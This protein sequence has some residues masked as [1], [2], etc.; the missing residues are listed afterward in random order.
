MKQVKNHKK[1][2][3]RC[4]QEQ[5]EY[6][7][8]FAEE[9]P[10]LLQKKICSSNPRQMKKLWEELAR[11]LNGMTGPTRNTQK[12]KETLNHW[13]IQVRCRARKSKTSLTS[14]GGGLL[15]KFSEITRLEERALATFGAIDGHS[16]LPS[17]RMEASSD[18]V[19]DNGDIKDMANTTQ[20]T[21][22]IEPESNEIKEE[23]YN[24][25]QETLDFAPEIHNIKQEI[26][27]EANSYR[28]CT[29]EQL[30]YYLAFV[31]KHPE[32]LQN[33]I[34]SANPRKTKT[35]W[36]ELAGNLNDMAGPTRNT[37]KWKETLNH[38]KYQLRGRARKGKISL[39][40]TLRNYNKM[41]KFEERA[42]A[43]FRA[44]AVKVLP[45]VPSIGMKRAIKCV[46]EEVNATLNTT[47]EVHNK[48]QET[49]NNIPG[50]NNIKREINSTKPDANSY[51]RCTQE[52]LEYYVTFV[53][54]HPELLQNKVNPVNPEQLKNL[55]E[56]LAGNL[57]SMAGPIRNTQKWKKTLNHWRNQLRSRARKGK[58]SC[59]RTLKNYN[60]MTRFDKRALATFGAIAGKV[61]P[62]V[63]SIEVEDPI[64]CVQDAMD[65]NGPLN[66]WQ[67]TNTMQEPL[68]TTTLD[69]DNIKQETKD[70]ALEW[71]NTSRMH[72]MHNINNTKKGI[73]NA[74]NKLAT[75]I[76]ERNDRG[77]KFWEEQLKVQQEL[78]GVI[79]DLTQ[80]LSKSKRIY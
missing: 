12:W 60:K 78:V 69:I 49:F 22:D 37:Q 52:Q 75:V 73:Y 8:A 72:D 15:R 11:N 10:E 27:I 21:H 7:L 33:K 39:N 25:T 20:E 41:T 66:N 31:E 5:V 3:Q 53:E 48:T 62:S 77:Q 26:I 68:Y 65:I 57:N 61:L 34:S 43:T 1:R 14:T 4:T 64:A 9:H 47:Q 76:K 51:Q 79:K 42:L 67:E 50:T 36:E 55:W 58:I 59:S 71:N 16:S 6:Y 32:L 70:T 80:V 46:Q 56:E 28:R 29:Q 38:W 23:I 35:L 45:S 19:Q 74:V 40:R 44:I 13:K 24:F 63:P 54:T 30:E 18:R 2:F 17:I